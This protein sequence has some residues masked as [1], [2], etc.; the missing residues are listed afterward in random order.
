MFVESGEPR[1][2]RFLERLGANLVPL[3]VA[4]NW[5]VDH[6]IFRPL[7]GVAKD[8]D[9]MM[10]ACWGDYKRHARVFAAL[11][12]LRRAGSR[13]KLVLAGYPAAGRTRDD[14][15]R[16]ARYYGVRD[17]VEFHERLSA[18]EVNY[19][20]NRCKVNLLWSRREGFN[21]SV[22]EGMFAD[23]PCVMREGFNYGHKYPYINAHTGRYSTERGLPATLLWMVENYR[24]FSPRAWVM[25]H[26]SCE[27]G[28]ELMEKAIRK[29]VIEAGA[30]WTRGLALKASHLDGVC[31]W[32]EG[33]RAA[34]REDYAFLS[35]LVRT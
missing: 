22:I 20:L 6:R 5:W 19:Q 27:R 33:D 34:F 15:C 32:D 11:R 35:S 28:T 16:Q 2:T 29:V 1:D 30:A 7:P 17:Q 25:G 31:Y 21:R 26:M 10:I 8:A 24:T 13:L 3:P 12:G 18:E 14:V 4:G 23:V 9:V